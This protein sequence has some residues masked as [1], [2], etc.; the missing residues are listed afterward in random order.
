MARKQASF[1]PLVG[2]KGGSEADPSPAL[3]FVFDKREG[4]KAAATF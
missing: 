3:P 1:I 2:P 4:V